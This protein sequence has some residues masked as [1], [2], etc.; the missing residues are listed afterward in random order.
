[1]TDLLADGSFKL[2]ASKLVHTV[3][4]LQKLSVKYPPPLER[5]VSGSAECQIQ[6][7]LL[8]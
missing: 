2:I 3:D 1:M 5:K 7:W 4:Y 8:D 6:Q